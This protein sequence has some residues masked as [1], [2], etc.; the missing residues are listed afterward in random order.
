[1]K[2]QTSVSYADPLRGDV[3]PFNELASLG[4]S[5]MPGFVA[6]WMVGRSTFATQL[7]Y[8]WPCWIYL[9]GQAHVG[10]GNA[11]GPHLDN[12]ALDKLRLSLD[13]GVGSVGSRD[14]GFEILFGVG[15]K[16][17]DQGTEIESVRLS[18]GSRKGF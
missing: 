7:A 16:T 12:L 10:V 4:G 17:F 11:F 5:L 2:L 18:F 1:L 6:G 3:V 14:Q 9:D 13:V 15:T 8:T